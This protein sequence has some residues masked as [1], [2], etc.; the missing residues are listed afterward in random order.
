MLGKLLIRYLR[1]Y[2]LLLLGVLVFQFASAMA[3][4]YLPRLNADIIDNGVARGDTA[5]I[6]S[7]GAI[8]LLIAL[9]QIVAAVIATLCAARAAMAAGRDIRRDVFQKVSGFSEREVSR[10]GPGTL[11]TRNT[12]DVQQVQMLAMMG[13]TMLVTAPM[14]AIGGIIMALQQDVGLSWLIGVSVPLLLVI[15]GVIISRMVPLFRQFQT[16]LDNV[17]RI[18][19]EQLTGVRVV[20]AFVRERIEEERFRGANTDIMI[21]GRKVGSL[22]VLMFPLAMLVL[23]VTVV[24]VIWFGGI[25]VDQ[26]NVQIGTLFAFMQYVGQI[27]MGVLMATFMTIM[28][29][30]A[31]VSADRIGEVLASHDALERPAEPVTTF[32]DPGAIVFDDVSFTYPGADS[33][34]LQGISFRAAPGETVAVVGSTGSGKTTLVSLIPRLFDVTGGAVR[35]AGVDVRRADLDQLWAGIGYVPQRAFLFTGTVA[36][37]LRFGREDATDDELWRALEI[38]QARDFVAEMEGGLDARIAQ[39]GTNVSGGQRQRL[40]IA[41]AIVRRPDVLVFDDSFSALDLATDARLR[42]ALWREL[43]D[44]TKIVVAQRI[45]TVTGADR[46]LVLDD[47]RMAGLGTHAE[48]LQ[49]NDTYRE[50]VQSQLGVDA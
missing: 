40:A 29:P 8:M 12:N 18:M 5:Y 2:R 42:E 4:L 1:T 44:V 46:I 23:N 14:L 38:A 9:G 48:L 47:G 13:A 31:A 33:A 30:R 6:W 50:I 41:R 43:P 27:L 34:V 24:G 10:F 17:N 28:I 22:F 36:S 39:G 21:V 11:I 49:S 3:S 25:Q 15:A 19:R 37:N 26:G 20:R 35:V 45:S 7:R 32:T 16:R